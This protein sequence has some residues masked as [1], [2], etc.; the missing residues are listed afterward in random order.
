MFKKVGSLI[1]LSPKY[2]KS[3]GAV[4]AL[5]VRRI[6]LEVIQAVGRDYP[7]DLIKKIRPTVYRAGVLTVECPSVATSEF[8]MRSEEII[9]EVNKKLGQVIL[10]EV[11]FK[12]K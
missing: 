2:S 8:F 10:R 5:M 7:E 3:S 9:E 11:K 1:K 12:N 4:S 6:A